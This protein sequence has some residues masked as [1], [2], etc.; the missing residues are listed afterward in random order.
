MGEAQLA[1][2]AAET[3]HE[4][5]AS[6][7]TT[8]EWLTDYF[9]MDDDSASQ[10]ELPD[11]FP[12]LTSARLTLL[13]GALPV[14]EQFRH[15]R[16]AY[17][18]LDDSLRYNAFLFVAGYPKRAIAIFGD[19]TSEESIEGL[20]AATEHLREVPAVEAPVVIETPVAA[21]PEKKPRGAR[22]IG[23]TGRVAV[24]RTVQRPKVD[25]IVDDNPQFGPR[26]IPNAAPLSSSQFAPARKLT[27]SDL[28]NPF[29]RPDYDPASP[30]DIEDDTPLSWQKDT[31]CSQTDP[32]A[33]FPEKGGSTRDA[34]KVCSG[35]DV[36]GECLQYALDN[37]ERFGIWGGLSER[38]RRKL[39]KRSA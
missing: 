18:S 21:Q 8:A 33:F 39:K 27:G 28:N 29:Q 23:S 36:R 4:Q 30:R 38:E 22:N 7:E 10:Y 11:S 6:A 25:V 2:L 35:C 37:D 19:D 15:A 32:E 20:F 34:K 5:M 26:I 12:T 9:L 24:S 16:E 13:V 17:G 3:E 31:I 14:Q 1:V